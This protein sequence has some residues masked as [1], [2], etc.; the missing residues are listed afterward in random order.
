MT[1]EG[2][3]PASYGD[4]FADIYD[5]WYPPTLQTRA[6]VDA[7]ARLAG[8]SPVLEL[9]CG[10]G[11]LCLP[12]LE[13][14]LE[15]DG[16]DA[17]EAMLAQLRAKPQAAALRAHHGDM[18]RFDLGRARFGLVFAAFNTL[19]NLGSAAEQAACFARVARHLRPGGR[20]V[21]ECFLP[22]GAA[23]DAEAGADSHNGGPGGAPTTDAIELRDLTADR[24]VLRI[25]RQDHAAQTVSGQHVELSEAGVRL[26][27]WHLRYASPA[28]LDTLAGQVGLVLEERWS[29]W[30]GAPFDEHADQHVS[31]YRH[32]AAPSPPGGL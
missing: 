12:L 15:V 22:A 29:D 27:P 14:G 8:G 1:V 24:V 21:I 18:A 19:F 13:R 6:A 17:S 2:Y 11:R 30:S 7:L 3:G 32:D 20:F 16:L 9:G 10:T 23:A 28:E 31:V 26:R 4:A 25:S 5:D